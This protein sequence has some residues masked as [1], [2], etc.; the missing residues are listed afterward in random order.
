ADGIT[1]V[2]SPHGITVEGQSL[3]SLIGGDVDPAEKEGGIQGI[4]IPR[5]TLFLAKLR[6]AGP[7]TADPQ[8]LLVIERGI[9]YRV[10]IEVMYS[11][12]QKDAG[13]RRFGL[14]AKAG[15]RLAQLPIV[16]PD[17]AP[18]PPST[19]ADPAD[20]PLRMIASVAKDRI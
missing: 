15:G 17:R 20:R 4:A 2:V 9:P 8:L 7:P 19:H 12:K 6:A 11:A 1:A 13:F 10:L 14:V 18:G 5:L 3:V 16:L